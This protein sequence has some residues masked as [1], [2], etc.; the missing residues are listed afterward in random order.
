MRIRPHPKWPDRD[1][2]L[3]HSGGFLGGKEPE[4][5]SGVWGGAAPIPRPTERPS[6]PPPY[7]SPLTGWRRAAALHAAAAAGQRAG[8]WQ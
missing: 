5:T 7:S 1:L 8:V 3:L 4:V 2:L 6:I